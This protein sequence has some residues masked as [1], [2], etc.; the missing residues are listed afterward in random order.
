MREL[1]NPLPLQFSIRLSQEEADYINEN[2][3]LIR[4]EDE[5]MPRSKIFVN[6]V[7]KAV[8]NVKPKEVIKEVPLPEL[9]Q[10]NEELKQT[11]ESLRKKCDDFLEKIN[12]LQVERENGILLKLNKAYKNYFWGMLEISK[13]QGYAQSY[14]E[15]FEKILQKFHERGEFVFTK[16]DIEYLK[17]LTSNNHE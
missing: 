17:Q 14:E 6:A 8:A 7:T 15:L 2:L 12:E 3:H 9:I 4:G 16:E 10:E 13:K 1:K 5:Q 11:V